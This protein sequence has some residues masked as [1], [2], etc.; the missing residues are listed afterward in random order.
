MPT[1][2][3]VLS[4]SSGE[5]YIPRTA[6]FFCKN[7]SSE[8]DLNGVWTRTL[9]A[10]LIGHSTFLRKY[11][12]KHTRE[13]VLKWRPRSLLTEPALKERSLWRTEVCSTMRCITKEQSVFILSESSARIHIRGTAGILE[14]PQLLRAVQTIGLRRGLRESSI[15][16]AN[17][18]CTTGMNSK[19]LFSSFPTHQGKLTL[20]EQRGYVQ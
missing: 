18:L 12:L 16:E 4:D 2:V 9:Q 20:P 6:G 19:V 10:T 3:F 14:D 13:N 1:A 7:P 5:T 15:R 11:C 8:L 17:I